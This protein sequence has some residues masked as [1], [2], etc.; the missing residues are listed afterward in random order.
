MQAVRAA[1]EARV[2]V[3]LV[4]PP[5]VGKTATIR[6][7]AKS[8]DYEII[9]LLGSQMDPTDVTGLP[10]GEVIAK[11]DEGND[12]WGTVYLSP[13]W[14]VRILQKKRVILFLDEYS[15]SSNAVRAAMLT[16]LQNREF[17]NG[18]AMPNETIV[19]GAM[20]PTDQAVDGWD[21]DM[22]T[23]NRIMFLN[24]KSPH[25]EWF[26]G[27]LNAWGEEITDDEKAWRKKI[28][29]FLTENPM[30]IHREN[31]ADGGGSP[32]ALGVDVNDPSAAEVLRYAWASRRSWDNL[33]R[34]LAF[35][36][37]T[38]TELQDEVASGTV[39]RASAIAFRAWLAANDTIDFQTVLAN[40]RAYDWA[41][42]TVS[43]ANTILSNVSSSIDASNWRQAL[44]LL[45]AVAEA[46]RVAIAVPFVDEI[47]K[48]VIMIAGKISAKE[49]EEAKEIVRPIFSLYLK[50]KPAEK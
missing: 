37:V 34:I 8:M 43:D 20:N 6:A 3:M 28:V 26:A 33:S 1:A 15:N 11:D 7:L 41:N 4:G 23:S 14:Q 48:S 47:V 32:E 44:D 35:T 36:S 21:L 5:G 27:M 25:A 10:K 17:A 40:P 42:S 30:Y 45:T 12:I 39:G 31:S 49:R 19:L 24:W 18:Q 2:P 46:D 29:S 22:P 38:D 13:W 9:T 50:N 16:L